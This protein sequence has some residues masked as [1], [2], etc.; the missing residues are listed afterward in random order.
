MARAAQATTKFL[1][2]K[3]PDTPLSSWIGSA[4]GILP[5]GSSTCPSGLTRVAKIPSLACHTTR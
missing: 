2:S 4:T 3:A 5:S 1:P